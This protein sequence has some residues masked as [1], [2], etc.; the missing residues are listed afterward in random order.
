[1]GASLPLGLP[2]DPY[3]K[4]DMTCFLKSFAPDLDPGPVKEAWPSDFE[5]Q[6]NSS[7]R[8]I[9]SEMDGSLGWIRL[10]RDDV[11][12]LIRKW[13]L[14]LGHTMNGGLFKENPFGI[15]KKFVPSDP[16]RDDFKMVQWCGLAAYMGYELQMYKEKNWPGPGVLV[17]AGDVVT[18]ELNG[19]WKTI[20]PDYK[21]LQQRF[22]AN[23]Q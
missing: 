16:A 20:V 6:N 5:R 21:I 18:V 22:R 17:E 10:D 7:I 15:V 12:K 4:E 13:D 9:L 1:M 19:S 14:D 11:D 8:D 23:T 3:T 2:P